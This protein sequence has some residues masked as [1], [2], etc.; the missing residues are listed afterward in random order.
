MNE[1]AIFLAAIEIAD[2][3]ERAAYLEQAC[4]GDPAL[5]KQVDS[6]LAAHERSGQFLDVPA[7]RQ[8]AAGPSAADEVDATS[9]EHAPARGEIDLAFLEPPSSPGS[10][11]R[12]MH[13]DVHQVIG[14]KCRAREQQTRNNQ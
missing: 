13:Y 11:G 14:S 1:Q 9:A 3:Q 2:L 4:G 12:L 10:L 7:L 5:R 8:M 6:L